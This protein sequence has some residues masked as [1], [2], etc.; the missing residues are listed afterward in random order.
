MGS[1][2]DTRDRLK[3]ERIDSEQQQFDIN[4]AR[5]LI[6]V[7][8]MPVNGVGVERILGERSMTPT[9]V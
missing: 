8:G 1:K 3:L 7:E 2:T 9:R 6:Y 4:S 5:R